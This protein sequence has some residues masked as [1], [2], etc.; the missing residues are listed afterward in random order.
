MAGGTT[1][2]VT[3]N[4]VNN[5]GGGGGGLQKEDLGL[6]AF[7]DWRAPTDAEMASSDRYEYKSQFGIA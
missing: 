5:Y 2:N 4:I 3:R 1:N 7:Q 6:M